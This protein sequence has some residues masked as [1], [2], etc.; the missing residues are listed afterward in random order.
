MVVPVTGWP[1]MYCTN[2]LPRTSLIQ[3]ILDQNV[4]NSRKFAGGWLAVRI[5]DG[6]RCSPSTSSWH[7]RPIL[8]KV[9]NRKWVEV[10]IQPPND[11]N[12]T[13][14]E[15]PK[16]SL[17]KVTAEQRMEM[18]G[19]TSFWAAGIKE[20]CVRRGMRRGVKAEHRKWG[21]CLYRKTDRKVS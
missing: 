16:T 4:I 13:I 14:T 11:F 20:C 8:A 12:R 19:E 21:R 18:S 2:W 10:S 17:G 3:D 15:P 9:E 7:V 5:H 6:W 1:L